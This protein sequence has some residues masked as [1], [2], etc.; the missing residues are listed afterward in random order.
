LELIEASPVGFLASVVL[1]AIGFFLALCALRG[2]VKFGLRFFF[3]HFYPIV[4]KETFVNAF[5]ANCC[6]MNL[7]M[8]ALI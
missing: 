6:V 7:W 3:I 2:N 1:I 5:M 8:C 4:P